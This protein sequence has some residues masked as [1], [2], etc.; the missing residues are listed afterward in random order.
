MKWLLRPSSLVVLLLVL[1]LAASAWVYWAVE[2]KTG[3]E[4]ISQDDREIA[5]LYTATSA[6]SW[7]RFV[8]ATRTALEHLKAG[9]P[10]LDLQV[11]DSRAFPQQTTAVPELVVSMPG[12]KG[13]LRF[14]WYKLTSQRKTG[15]WVEMLVQEKRAPLAV[16]GGS[17]SDLAIELAQQLKERRQAG[18]PSPLLLLTTATTDEVSMPDGQLVKLNSIYSLTYRFCFTN[19]QIARVVTDFIWHQDDL[20]PDA[21][22]IYLTLWQ[23]DPYSVDLADRFVKVLLRSQFQQFRSPEVENIPYSL[24]P[25]DRPNHWEADAARDLVEKLDRCFLGPAHLVGESAAANA[26]VPTGVPVGA[27]VHTVDAAKSAVTLYRVQRQPLLILPASAQPARRFLRGLMDNAPV[28]APRFVVATGDAISFNTVYRDR[29]V[30]WPIQDLPF[31]LVLFCHRN[32][33]DPE[34]GFLTESDAQA[35]AGGKGDPLRTTGTEDLLLYVDMVEA[36]VQASFPGAEKTG[37]RSRP[38]ARNWD[39][40]CVRPA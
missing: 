9:Q 6:A 3:A 27:L 31:R 39:G 7:E 37:Q 4:P 15:D 22:P 13:K 26:V 2:Q 25:F 24:G 1:L 8:T 20:R 5:W 23:D 28:E 30:A 11:D 16:I 21:D 38:A 33:V 40:Y 32:P 34:A 36:L 10:G 29:A 19:Q 18:R 12:S 17:S 14:R 35:L